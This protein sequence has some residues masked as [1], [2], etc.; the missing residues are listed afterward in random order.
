M[1]ITPTQPQPSEVYKYVQV[2]YPIVLFAG[3]AI[4]FNEG[5]VQFELG[6]PK[7]TKKMKMDG[8]KYTV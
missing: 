1:M 3:D 8:C 7:K 6:V 5:F 4:I 2:S